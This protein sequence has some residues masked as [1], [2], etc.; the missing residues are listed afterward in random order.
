[1]LI[2]HYRHY[3][4]AGEGKCGGVVL[5]VASCHTFLGSK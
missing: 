5:L 3:P 1:M 4:L 2:S